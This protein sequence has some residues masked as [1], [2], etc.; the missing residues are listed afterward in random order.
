MNLGHHLHQALRAHAALG[1]RVEARFDC[2]HGQQ[3]KRVET[4]FAACVERC[5]H[6]LANGLLSDAIAPCQVRRD[7]ILLA[8]R[9]QHTIVACVGR[10]ALR[11]DQPRQGG[12]ALHGARVEAVQRRHAHAGRAGA[13]KGTVVAG[14]A[15]GNRAVRTASGVAAGRIRGQRL[16][17]GRSRRPESRQR[18]ALQQTGGTGLH[19]GGNDRHQLGGKGAA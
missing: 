6:E 3:K 10:D 13:V 16:V 9:D 18:V 14:I 7:Q 12:H 15:G 2:H 8:G 11:R 17:R 1:V 19:S 5:L 4:D